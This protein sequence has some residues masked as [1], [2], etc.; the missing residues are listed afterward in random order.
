MYK[1]SNKQK[2]FVLHPR[3]PFAGCAALSLGLSIF[4][5]IVCSL[6]VMTGMWRVQ[7][8]LNKQ[9]RKVALCL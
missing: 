9:R 5:V 3:S 4:K 6:C 1:K 7:T 8:G 2:D